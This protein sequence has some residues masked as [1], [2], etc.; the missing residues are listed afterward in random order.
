MR[1]ATII[2]A[3]IAL[4]AL[5]QNAPFSRGFDLV[6][7]KLTP[8]LNSG[9]ALEGAELPAKG[10]YA[11]GAVIDFNVGILSLKLASQRLGDLLPYR[12]DLH[13]HGAWQPFSRLEL[14]ADLP[15]TLYQ[16]SGF[17][18]LRDQGFVDQADPAAGGL[19]DWRFF[20]RVMALS[21]KDFPIAVAGVLEVRLPLGDGGSFLGDNGVVFAP[22]AAVERVLGPLRF[23]GNVGWRLRTYPGQF[24][25]LYVGQEFVLGGGLHVALPDIGRTT[26][27]R[28]LA[29]VSI[30]TPAEA[31]FTSA[32]AEA[33][34]TPFELLVGA[35]S[36]FARSWHAQL[37][38]GRGLAIQNGYGRE[39]FRLAGGIRYEFVPESDRDGDGIPDSLDKC[40]DTPEDKDGYQDDDGCP[41]PDPDSDGDGI[42]DH[43][44]GC[45]DQPGP[46]DYDG[47]PDRDG[48]QIP[49]NVDKC[50]DEPG[51]AE[52]EGCPV[53]EDE[54]VTLESDRIRIKGNILFETGQ[55]VIQ[56]QSYKLLDDVVK[57]LRE[58][59][60]V[61]PVMIEGNTDN[62]GSHDYN[63]DLSNRRAKAV[64]D[65]LVKGGID[66]KRLRSKG[67]SFDKPVASND[68]PV[69]RAKNRRTE[70]RLV[71]EIE[72]PTKEKPV[73]KDKKP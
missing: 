59:P 57:V 3:L 63:L 68:T 40:P 52:T 25:N 18:L 35:R 16:R 50:P 69:G 39:T 14:A 42:P 19:G 15:F 60:E 1:C 58:H 33:L 8:T 24:L 54:Q 51:P 9:L 72:L 44:D 67:F 11:F 2:A 20:A 10:S 21:Q 29:E 5:A 56:R 30:S 4:P 7:N 73:E 65:Y 22:R 36:S 12:F 47:C 45:K 46:S 17:S 61:G 49:D 53:P 70:F 32:Q 43:L 34:K 13:L 6:P 41:E 38:V 71:E 66:R 28:I 55:A 31:P 48:D 23:M 37:T 62:R 26:L 64:E 27:N